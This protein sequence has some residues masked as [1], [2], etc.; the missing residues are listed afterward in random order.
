MSIKVKRKKNI[1][2]GARDPQYRAGEASTDYRN[3]HQQIKGGAGKGGIRVAGGKEGAIL[4]N[5]R[6]WKK[7][8]GKSTIGK[9][10]MR[11]TTVDKDVDVI[12]N[13]DKKATRMRLKKK[14]KQVAT[15]KSLSPYAK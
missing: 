7:Y 6:G 3:P 11:E 1:V 9:K 8:R 5:K 10:K 2:K 4:A 13:W 14:G 12:G 15:R